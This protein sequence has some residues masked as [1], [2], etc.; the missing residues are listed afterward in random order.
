MISHQA[1]DSTDSG[2]LDLAKSHKD[3]YY[4]QGHTLF[5]LTHPERFE[6]LLTEAYRYFNH[7]AQEELT[8]SYA[9]E[10]LL[11]NFYIVRQTLALIDK[12]MPPHYYDELARLRH[13]GYPRIY[14]I[15]CALSNVRLGQFTGDDIVQF[16]NLYQQETSL[17]MGEL[18]ALPTM[19]RIC[20]LEN[21][22]RALSRTAHLEVD[23][24]VMSGEPIPL[25][26]DES[27]I[28]NCII[29]FR[30]LSTEDWNAFFEQVSTVEQILKTDPAGIYIQTTFETR[31]RC[32][33][34]IED[35]GRHM[36]QMVSEDEIAQAA[37]H[38]AET[39][40]TDSYSASDMDYENFKRH[41]AY[42]LIDEGRQELEQKLNYHPVG[43]ERIKTFARDHTT[44]IYL[45]SIA[46]ST[47]FIILWLVASRH[48]SVVQSLLLVTLLVFPVSTGAIKL[49]DWL[50]NRLVKPV[51]LPR[52]DFYAGIPDQ[53]KTFVVMP[54]LIGNQ[55]DIDELTEQLEMHYLR[56]PDPNLRFALLADFG[57][58]NSEHLP[59]DEQLARYGQE[60]IEQLNRGYESQP[61][62]LFLRKR[63]WNNRE[64]TWMGWERKR[65]KLE[66]FNQFLLNPDVPHNDY[67]LRVGNPVAAGSIKYV[68]T[69][70]ADTILPRDKA[71]ALVATLAHPLNRAVFDASGRRIVRGY[72]VLQP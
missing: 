26:A 41:V 38:L 36:N 40:D 1:W 32:R 5:I 19:L 24:P 70:D 15:A 60:R 49:V 33:Q 59:A 11:D 27:I 69:L 22:A 16:L 39:A 9:G 55:A 56:N 10:W 17:R 71:Q 14:E 6:D 46:L 34:V 58:A 63:R 68:I 7:A 25:S 53:F 28:A 43:F 67:V 64:Q 3:I 23:F 61:F 54:V 12:D 65:G 62:Y 21:L 51:T 2:V 44:L 50:V 4:G 31:N 29:T 72:G 20:L 8:V 47:F 35:L 66:M 13:T 45:G 57:D 42:Y 52:M 37:I 18:W 48:G 30:T